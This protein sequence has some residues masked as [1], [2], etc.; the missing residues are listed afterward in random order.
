MGWLLLFKFLRVLFWIMG[1]GLGAVKAISRNPENAGLA[2]WTAST[3][4]GANLE[5]FAGACFLAAYLL[6]VWVE[7]KSGSDPNTRKNVVGVLQLVI[8]LPV[9][10]WG[11]LKEAYANVTKATP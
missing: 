9:W 5:Y 6:G 7:Y 4:F 11:C 2:Q 3:W 10:L 8:G 1:G